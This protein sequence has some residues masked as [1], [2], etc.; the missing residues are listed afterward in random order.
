MPGGK[1]AERVPD[2]VCGT[3]P[4]CSL[5]DPSKQENRNGSRD[6]TDNGSGQVGRQ[7][8]WSRVWSLM[9]PAQELQ[10]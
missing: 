3:S 9:I 2:P 5:C 7:W 8:R 6:G 1:I 10:L 4:G